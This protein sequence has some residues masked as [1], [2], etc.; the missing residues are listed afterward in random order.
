MET[1]VC[2]HGSGDGNLSHVFTM[3]LETYEFLGQLVHKANWDHNPKQG[4]SY[5]MFWFRMRRQI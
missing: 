3:S 1:E 2:E 5:L 4:D